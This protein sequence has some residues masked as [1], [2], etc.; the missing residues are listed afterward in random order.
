MCQFELGQFELC[1]FEPWVGANYCDG[2]A[3]GPRLLILGESHYGS[4]PPERNF[5][6][7]FTR[8]YAEGQ[9]DDRFWTGI[10]QTVLGHTRAEIEQGVDILPING[11]PVIAMNRESFW[12]SVALY[13]YIQELLPGPRQ[14]PPAPAWQAARPAFE[15]VLEALKPQALLVHGKRL[16]DHL[17]GPTPCSG[18]QE[19]EGP[20][21][22][23]GELDKHAWVYQL[24]NGHKVLAAGVHHP[25]SPGFNWERWHCVVSALLRE[26]AQV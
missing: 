10:M 20:H 6:Q 19:Y 1:Q 15:A 18:H 17:P 11:G 23:A 4:G 2:F 3:G 22:N 5:T 12:Q 9:W 7:R 13:N 25:S 14:A 26:A 21:L 16:W 8:Q 24:P